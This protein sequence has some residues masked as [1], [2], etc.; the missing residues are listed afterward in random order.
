MVV[1]STEIEINKSPEEVR[2]LVSGHASPDS[3]AADLFAQFLDFESWKDW[4][5]SFT[6]VPQDKTKTGATLVKGD[7]L[8]VTIPDMSFKPVMRVSQRKTRPEPNGA[9]LRVRT[10]R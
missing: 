5:S 9:S 8:S 6:V 2:K 1:I 4:Q 10:A 7:K 3:T